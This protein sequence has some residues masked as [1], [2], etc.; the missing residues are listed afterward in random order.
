M[1][2]LLVTHFTRHSVI[3]ALAGHHPLWGRCTGSSCWTEALAIRADIGDIYCPMI[4][5][6]SGFATLQSGAPA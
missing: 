3:T 6:D 5:T 1:L 2:Y 4:S